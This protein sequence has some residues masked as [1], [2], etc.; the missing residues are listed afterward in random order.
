MTLPVHSP[1]RLGLVMGTYA[2]AGLRYRTA[3]GEKRPA[4]PWGGRIIPW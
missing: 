3:T 1:D 2:A 4:P